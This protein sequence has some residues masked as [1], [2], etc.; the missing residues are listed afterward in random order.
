MTQYIAR[1]LLLMVGILFGVLVIPPMLCVLLGYGAGRI[2]HGLLGE[3][4]QQIEY[5]GTETDSHH[6]LFVPYG[7][8]EI[9][10]DGVAPE[11]AS[12][13]GESHPV[14]STSPIYRGS[15]VALYSPFSTPEGSSAEFVA[16]QI[17]R[18]VEAVY[19]TSIPPEA[20]RERYLETREDG[21]VILMTD[22]LTLAEDYPDLQAVGNPAHTPILLLTAGLPSLLLL[23]GLFP[24]VRTGVPEIRQKVLFWL[25]A[26]LCLALY[27]G[28]FAVTMFR[29]MEPAVANGFFEISV[30]YLTVAV[31][32]GAT[33]I[34][35]ACV[36]LLLG[37]YR[38]AQRQFVKVEPAP[39]RKSR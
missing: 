4:A 16:L 11:N 18:A 13:W 15:R 23:A 3:R 29:F 33:S 19:G 1:R 12:P 39:C 17:S 31:P 24:T 7:A 10:W 37:A 26:G 6:Y 22:G 20:I 30:R 14:A 28:S 8:S 38:M 35:I 9:A 2:G 5:R 27:L 25:V 34:W 21:E 36:L 32:G